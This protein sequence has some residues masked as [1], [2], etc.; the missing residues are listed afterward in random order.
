MAGVSIA[1]GLSS[2]LRERVDMLPPQSR[3]PLA[4]LDRCLRRLGSK[5]LVSNTLMKN[6]SVET[7][8]RTNVCPGGKDPDPRKGEPAWIITNLGEDCLE[9]T[10]PRKG[11]QMTRDWSMNTERLEGVKRMH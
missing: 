6:V 10:A 8:E 7:E 1:V 11:N 9:M 3:R 2:P 4:D 5:G